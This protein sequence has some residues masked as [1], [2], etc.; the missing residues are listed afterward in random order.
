LQGVIDTARAKL[1]DATVAAL[2]A[3]ARLDPDRIRSRLQRDVAELS[4]EIEDARGR[5]AASG[6]TEEQMSKALGATENFLEMYRRVLK[7]I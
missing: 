2:V 5:M 7:A 3:A 6:A 4:Q 1:S